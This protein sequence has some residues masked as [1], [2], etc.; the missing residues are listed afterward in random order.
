MCCHAY[1]PVCLCCVYCHVIYVLGQSATHN[2]SNLRITQLIRGAVGAK[3]L[4]CWPKGG[5]LR[6]EATKGCWFWKSVSFSF[7]F[8][9]VQM[10]GHSAF[11]VCVIFYPVPVVAKSLQTSLYLPF[12]KKMWQLINIIQTYQGSRSSYLCK[13][14]AVKQKLSL[15]L[16]LGDICVGVHAKNLWW[17]VEWQ[18]L[19]VF[20]VTVIL[21][22]RGRKQRERGWVK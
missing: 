18:R 1:T 8:K 21:W 5:A 4:A 14:D 7:F 9:V 15:S 12:F 2:A 10:P 22:Q 6:W 13:Q 19:G 20:Y 17:R 16:V 3:G 11:F